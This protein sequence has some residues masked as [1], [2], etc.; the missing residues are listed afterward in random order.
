MQYKSPISSIWLCTASPRRARRMVP[1][2]FLRDRL[3]FAF[4]FVQGRPPV[5]SEPSRHR[6][7]PRYR[8]RTSLAKE[9]LDTDINGYLLAQPADGWNVARFNNPLQ[10]VRAT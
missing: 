5:I 9:R 1:G 10:H 7:T 3:H 6:R 2:S 8:L 4:F